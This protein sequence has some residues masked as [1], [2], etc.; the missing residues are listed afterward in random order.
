MFSSSKKTQQAIQALRD[1]LNTLRQQIAEEKSRA[2]EDRNIS[3]V[4]AER[5]AA[6]EVRVSG[7]GSE[8]SRQ[9]H[10]LGTEIEELSKRADDAAVMEVV[11]ALKTAQIRLATEQARYEITFRQDL[12]ALADQL[13]KRAR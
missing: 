13:F 9:L 4:I 1:E 5:I 2:D 3:L 10:E 11:D 8:L 6:L 7:M 12:A